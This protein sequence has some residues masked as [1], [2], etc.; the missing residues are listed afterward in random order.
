MSQFLAMVSESWFWRYFLAHFGWVDWLLTLFIFVGILL[1]L[2]NGLS[3]ELPRLLES[4]LSLYATLEYYGVLAGWLA[5]ETPWPESYCRIFTFLLIWF[6]A[7]ILLRLGFEIIGRLVHLEIAAP[8]QSLG[9]F[10]V[11]GLRY[12]LFASMVSYFLVLIPLDWTQSSYKVNSW[13]GGVLIQTPTKIY[14]GINR[15]LMTGKI[16]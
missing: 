6:S 9:G 16:G 8:F 14:E 3:R 7:S 12:F 5:R 4:L 13:S 10:L 1:G 2:K 11:G 15:L